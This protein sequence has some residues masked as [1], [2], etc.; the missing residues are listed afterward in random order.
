[1]GKLDVQGLQILASPLAPSEQKGFQGA[2]RPLSVN[3]IQDKQ[4]KLPMAFPFPTG[5]HKHL[6]AFSEIR[7]SIDLVLTTPLCDL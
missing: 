7:N 6:P 5:L 1:M 2:E 3:L 4:G